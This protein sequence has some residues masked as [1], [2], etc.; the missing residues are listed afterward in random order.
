MWKA[1]ASPSESAQAPAPDARAPAEPNPP[2]ARPAAGAGPAAI[3]GPSISI[4]GEISGSED[5][6]IEGQVEG[7]V[8]LHQHNVTVASSGRVTADIRGKRICVDGKVT[9][10]LLGEEVVIRKSGRVQGNAKAPKVTLENGCY[11]RGSIDMQPRNGEPK[12]AAAAK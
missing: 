12:R 5:L 4:K 9:G 7:A 6:V 10:D 1:N 11:F 8:S 2:P 3:I